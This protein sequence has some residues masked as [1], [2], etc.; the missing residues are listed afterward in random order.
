MRACA[1]I[2]QAVG[3]PVEKA[4]TGRFVNTP[5]SLPGSFACPTDVN[6]A[7]RTRKT[8]SCSPI[9]LSRCFERPLKI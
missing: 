9:A 8:F 6:I 2:M 3:A 1:L 4:G 5:Q 7:G